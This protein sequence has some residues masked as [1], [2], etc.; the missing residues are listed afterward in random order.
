MAC[1]TCEDGPYPNYGVGPHMCFFKL[2]GKTIGE[3]VQKPKEEWPDNYTEDPECPG[4]GIWTCPD[5]KSE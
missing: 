4:L 3:S 2:P 5:C 1:K